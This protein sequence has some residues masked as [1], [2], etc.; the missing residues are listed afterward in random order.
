MSGVGRECLAHTAVVF[1]PKD[2]LKTGFDAVRLPRASC[3]GPVAECLYAR[4]RGDYGL[5]ELQ[6]ARKEPD[7]AGSWMFPGAV[8]S[9]GTALVATPIH[10]IFVCL[11][12]M[13]TSDFVD[14]TELVPEALSEAVF[15]HMDAESGP[16]VVRRAAR[17]F[18]PFCTTREFGGSTVFKLSPRKTVLWLKERVDAFAGGADSP[19]FPAQPAFATTACGSVAAE[20]AAARAGA[21]PAAAAHTGR[22]RVSLALDILAEYMTLP[23]LQLL[24]RHCGRADYAPSFAQRAPAVPRSA[25]QRADHRA[26]WRGRRQESREQPAQGPQKKPRVLRANT[27]HAAQIT[28]FFSPERAGGKQ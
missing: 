19:L 17:A 15:G 27:A 16:D 5:Y 3:R 4:S 26:Q 11:P 8:V 10:P 23:W 25:A 13:R 24:A 14:A 21:A 18:E 28:A 6:R 1:G 20:L 7:V 12:F 22:D 2:L 9:D